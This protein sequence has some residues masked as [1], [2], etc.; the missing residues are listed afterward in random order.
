MYSLVF[1]IMFLNYTGCDSMLQFEAESGA[2][3]RPWE[4]GLIGMYQ[5][6]HVIV[7]VLLR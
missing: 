4:A 1:G 7:T 2:S 5:R 3:G 6:Q